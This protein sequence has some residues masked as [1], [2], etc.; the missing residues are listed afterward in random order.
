MISLLTASTIAPKA[1][2]ALAAT[3]PSRA[4]AEARP[5][6]EPTPPQLAT[7]DARRAAEGQRKEMA[8]RRMQS[9]WDRMKTLSLMIRADPRSALKMAAELARELKAA[10]K[11]YVEAGGRNVS[12]GD[13]ALL[14]RRAADA[15]DAT[16]DATGAAS[17]AVPD[18]PTPTADAR[19][20]ADRFRPAPADATLR[21]A[22]QAYAFAAEI[23]ERRQATVDDL[24]AMEATATA[25]LGFFDKV[26]ILAKDLR[27][28]QEEIR[29]KAVFAV[30]KP[31]DEDW[32]DAARAQSELEKQIDFAPT[33]PPA[34][35]GTAPASIRA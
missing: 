19:V 12:S 27:K 30:R 22:G 11:A 13:L 33:G 3:G 1:S 29:A 2:A 17:Q 9:V 23:A 28:A 20:D 25:D 31:T 18:A 14:R 4:R 35:S 15:R 32:T 6:D 5:S 21:Q 10:V 8:Y 34:P 16:G 7:T 26:K 24:A